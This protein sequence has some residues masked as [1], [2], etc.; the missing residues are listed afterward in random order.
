MASRLKVT[1]RRSTVGVNPSARG[2]VRA[3][4]LRRIGQTVELRIGF[5][6][7]GCEQAASNLRADGGGAQQRAPG[8]HRVGRELQRLLQAQEKRVQL[9]GCGPP[10][11]LGDVIDRPLGGAEIEDRGADVVPRSRPARARVTSARMPSM[12]SS[13]V[14]AA[15]SIRAGATSP[16]PRRAMATPGFTTSEGTKP[17]SSM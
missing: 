12:V 2:T 9:L 4:G 17:R 6:L 1:L 3:L 11:G 15:A 10:R 14:I 5:S 16:P 13:S 8:L 7:R